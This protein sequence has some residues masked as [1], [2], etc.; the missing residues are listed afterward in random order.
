MDLECIKTLKA[1]Q[2]VESKGLFRGVCK[3]PIVWTLESERTGSGLLTLRGTYLGV[4]IGKIVVKAQHEKL[5][6]VDMEKLK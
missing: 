2:P 6:C 3:D 1:G 5:I 4:Y